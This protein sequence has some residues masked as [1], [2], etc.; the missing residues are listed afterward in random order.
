[1]IV[2]GTVIGAPATARPASPNRRCGHLSSNPA[3]CRLRACPAVLTR[4]AFQ[5]VLQSGRIRRRNGISGERSFQRISREES[6][7]RRVSRRSNGQMPVSGQHPGESRGNISDTELCESPSAPVCAMASEVDP[8]AGRTHQAW[9]CFSAAIRIW[10]L[11]SSER[12]VRTGDPAIG[13]GSWGVST[14]RRGLW[15][16]H[17]ALLQRSA[18]A[19]CA[20]VCKI[21]LVRRP[22][23]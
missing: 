22:D 21:T 20:I 4:S 17:G 12:A 8:L 9:N 1:M 18:V 13:S 15:A 6:W 7:L 5:A 19:L 2:P 11:R 10:P 3:I 23:G 16:E 14:S